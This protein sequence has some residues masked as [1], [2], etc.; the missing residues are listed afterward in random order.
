MT[1]Y[2]VKERNMIDESF[3]QQLTN[4]ILQKIKWMTVIYNMTYE[5]ALA[6]VKLTLEEKDLINP[7]AYDRVEQV[8]IQ[9]V[10]HNRQYKPWLG[11]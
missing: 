4:E 8:T 7:E 10:K 6:R 1:T 2:T 3:I 11:E 5:E 9:A